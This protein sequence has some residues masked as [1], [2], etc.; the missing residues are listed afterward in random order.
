MIV[1]ADNTVHT[2][3]LLIQHRP[4]S[5]V[6]KRNRNCLSDQVYLVGKKRAQLRRPFLRPSKNLLSL[7]LVILPFYSLVLLLGNGQKSSTNP[8]PLFVSGVHLM[9]A[10][11]APYLFWALDL[12]SP[13]V[14]NARDNWTSFITSTKEQTEGA[15]SNPAPLLAFLMRTPAEAPALSAKVHGGGKSYR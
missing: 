14:L 7:F 10:L 5:I 6:P 1:Q 13:A 4:T 8:Y 15:D 3:L 9:S 12:P 11:L 2:V